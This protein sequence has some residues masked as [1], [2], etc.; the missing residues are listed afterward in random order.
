MPAG[1][2]FAG[3]EQASPRAPQV[4]AYR[5]AVGIGRSAMG[6]AARPLLRFVVDHRVEDARDLLPVRQLNLTLS[7]GEAGE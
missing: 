5:R 2:W 6:C 4:V 3:I 7:I 1:W